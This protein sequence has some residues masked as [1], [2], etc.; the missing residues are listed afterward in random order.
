M[1]APFSGHRENAPLA[2]ESPAASMPPRRIGKQPLFGVTRQPLP[3]CTPRS[4]DATR[5]RTSPSPSGPVMCAGPRRSMRPP[6]CG[7]IAIPTPSSSVE[8]L[9]FSV[10]Q[11]ESVS[12]PSVSN[13]AF[14]VQSS[15]S[16]SNDAFGAPPPESS[17]AIAPE[18]EGPGH[19]S[20]MAGLSWRSGDNCK[21]VPVAACTSAGAETCRR[22]PSSVALIASGMERSK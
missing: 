8:M 20:T 10:R 13:G 7:W 3:H 11:F 2:K 12:V 22:T 17:S 14:G 5:S 6:P 16:S 9:A 18:R 1:S 4:S 21:R 19:C 15:I